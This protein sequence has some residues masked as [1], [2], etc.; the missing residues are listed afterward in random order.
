MLVDGKLANQAE[1][2]FQGAMLKNKGRE[3][4]LHLVKPAELNFL[5][6]FVFDGRDAG[7]G[8]R[9]FL[10]APGAAAPSGIA[11]RKSGMIEIPRLV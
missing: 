6:G 9:C 3:P 1:S 7:W 10:L 4:V 11:D 2:S 8:S 5:L